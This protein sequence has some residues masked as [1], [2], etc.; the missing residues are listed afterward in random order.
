MVYISNGCRNHLWFDWSA[1]GLNEF[2][3]WKWDDGRCKVTEGDVK[4]FLGCYPIKNTNM[5]LVYRVSIAIVTFYA[6]RK[7]A[8]LPSNLE[9]Y[10]AYRLANQE[11]LNFGEIFMANVIETATKKNKALL[12]H[13]FIYVMLNKSRVEMDA[14]DVERIIHEDFYNMVNL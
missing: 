5:P 11:L 6:N 2:D 13:N 1:Q 8:K 4:S 12:R 9:F 14:N 3:V 7:F 10:I